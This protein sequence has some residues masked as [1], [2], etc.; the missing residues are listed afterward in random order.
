M[1]ILSLFGL[2]LLQEEFYVRKIHDL[3]SSFIYQMPFK[4]GRFIKLSFYEVYLTTLFVNAPPY[5]VNLFINIVCDSENIL[6]STL[7]AYISLLIRWIGLPLWCAIVTNKLE[8]STQFCQIRQL[9][10]IFLN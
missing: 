4:V 7:I 6:E 3:I 10:S 1:C 2:L 8:L 9:G 5:I